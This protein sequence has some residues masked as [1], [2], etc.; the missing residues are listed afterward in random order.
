MFDMEEEEE[1]KECMWGIRKLSLALVP[2]LIRARQ[3]R[4]Y[5]R[6]HNLCLFMADNIIVM[7]RVMGRDGR[8]EV[9]PEGEI[10]ASDYDGAQE[11]GRTACEREVRA[12]TG[13]VMW[14]CGM[15]VAENL[16]SIESE[17]SRPQP[18]EDARVATG[19][20]RRAMDGVEAAEHR[21]ASKRGLAFVESE[22]S[23]P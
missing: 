6:G 5:I 11:A 20:T 17:V 2:C 4:T 19:G 7:I 1:D 16:A 14:T 18:T 12:E 13:R 15:I 22:V 21:Q 9:G 10:E 3:H 23:S 8:D